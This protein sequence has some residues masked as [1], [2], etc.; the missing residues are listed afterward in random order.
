MKPTLGWS[1]AKTEKG[2]V[3]PLTGSGPAVATLRAPPGQCLRS[4]RPHSQR[5]IATCAAIVGVVA[6]GISLIAI[7]LIPTLAM[8]APAIINI[9]PGSRNNGFPFPDYFNAPLWVDQVSLVASTAQSYTVPTPTGA[10]ATSYVF[11]RI[12]P[13]SALTYGDVTG[14]AVIPAAGIT[15]GTGSFL[16]PTQGYYIVQVGTAFSMICA[17]ASVVTIEV[18][19]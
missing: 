1:S 3:A 8:A 2:L 12:S 16:I 5:A 18:W 19:Q 6:K 11:L 14:T 4:G 15:N 10:S 7:C 13:G 9:I 17:T